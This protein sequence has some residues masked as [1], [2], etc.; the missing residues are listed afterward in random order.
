MKAVLDVLDK[1]SL[2]STFGQDSAR[3]PVSH[4]VKPRIPVGGTQAAAGCL[5]NQ[6]TLAYATRKCVCSSY[7]EQLIAQTIMN[8]QKD[9]SLRVQGNLFSL[10][11]KRNP[12]H[13]TQKRDDTQ[14]VLHFTSKTQKC[15]YRS[16]STIYQDNTIHRRLHWNEFIQVKPQIIIVLKQSKQYAGGLVETGLIPYYSQRRK[17][18]I[19]ST[20][21]IVPSGKV[22]HKARDNHT[23][24][25]NRTTS[26]TCTCRFIRVRTISFKQKPSPDRHGCHKVMEPKHKV[27][28]TRRRGRAAIEQHGRTH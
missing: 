25:R 6:K 12:P 22:W 2:H 5:S 7:L 24:W 4:L 14:K 28:C 20:I 8:F 27:F 26:T 10:W 16:S 15:Y 17:P 21:I 18:I 13:E 1:T 9:N 19:G 3:H 11:H 23:S